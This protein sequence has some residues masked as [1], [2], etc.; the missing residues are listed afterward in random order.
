MIGI[1]DYGVGNVRA[2]LNI[3]ESL[4]I[5]AMAVQQNNDIS[6]CSKYILPGVGHF[7][8][9]MN[10]FDESGLREEIEKRVLLDKAPILG[11]CVGMQMLANGSDEGSE[12]GL[13]WIP[14]KVARFDTA[15]ICHKPYLPH[16]GWNNITVC[17]HIPLV[18]GLN[19][20]S[21]FYFL[22][23]YYFIPQVEDDR[24]LSTRYGENNFT[25]LV[26]RENIFGC[27]FHP[28]KSHENGIRLLE[29]FSR[30]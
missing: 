28:E 29:N 13:G 7:D 4:E 2:F 5:P 1:L 24:I 3:Y 8:Y 17:K 25:S 15:S 18:L 6:K 10:K 12:R 11:I 21:L 9:A 30:I 19:S 22:H 27:Q 16:M 14:G 20:S 23:S 26:S